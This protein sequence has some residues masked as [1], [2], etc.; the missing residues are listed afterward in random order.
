MF[1]PKIYIPHIYI[2]KLLFAEF[3]IL[4]TSTKYILNIFSISLIEAIAIYSA[5]IFALEVKA[6]NFS[7]FWLLKSLKHS[8]GE[9]GIK[10]AN[11]FF[12]GQNL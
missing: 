1:A 5:E 7:P 6:E 9:T 3:Q 12:D 4:I 2:Y 10:T 11:L 8:A